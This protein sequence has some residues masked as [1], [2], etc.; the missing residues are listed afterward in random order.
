M[1]D[2]MVL[3]NDAR[4]VFGKNSDRDPGEP[5]LIQYCSGSEGL[6]QASHPERLV[7]YD[8]RQFLHLQEAS[9]EYDSPFK[10]LISRPSWMWGAEM[11]V[12]ERGVAIGNEAVFSTS[13][14]QK[15]GLLGMD[16]LRL[17]L[18]NAESGHQAV[19]LIVDLI[20]RFGQGGDASYKG[21]LSYHNSFLIQDRSEAFVLETAGTS[22]AMKKT[23]PSASISNVYTLGCDYDEADAVTQAKHHHF[24]HRHASI[25]HLLFTQGHVRQRQSAERLSLATPTWQGIR[26]ILISNNGTQ[27]T[28]D[29]SMRSICMDSRGLIKSQ[30]TGS[31]VVESEGNMTLAWM[32]GAPAPNFN[33]F[34]PFSL[35]KTA[36]NSEEFSNP[37]TSYAFALNKIEQTKKIR[38]AT[39]EVQVKI[40]TWARELED[41]FEN[42]IRK[43]FN[44]Q[45]AMALDE[46]CAECRRLGKIHDTRVDSLLAR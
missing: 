3:R 38:R 31:L 6:A 5:Q 10:A 13:P 46:A 43:P 7:K 35:S 27:R 34:F 16:I 30:T 41:S 2:T 20:K 8:T 26:D 39:V 14:V 9:R 17:V 21:H 40:A 23:N 33:P 15:D 19:Q 29:Y 37:M 24:T 42:L 11:G 36:F 1:C 32:T 12:N 22:W 28:P 18:H 25:L 45:D 44:L 4:I